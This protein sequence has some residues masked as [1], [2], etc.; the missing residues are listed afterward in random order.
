MRLLLVGG[1]HLKDATLIRKSLGLIHI[2]MQVSV[3]I[4]GGHAALGTIA[5]DW[6][7]ESDIHILRYPANWR[8]L[9][10]RAEGVRNDFMLSDSRPDMVL[11]LPGGD[12]TRA[13]IVKALVLGVPVY[14]PQAQ[15]VT[16]P[17]AAP[18]GQVI[19]LHPARRGALYP[20]G[21]QIGRMRPNDL[22]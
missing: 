3:L 5:E 1:R 15:P 9:G 4:H 18:P 10:K 2:R 7:R 20:M 8:L 17:P 6:A 16:I 11:A 21:E 14:D 13:L 12:D 19:D 22:A